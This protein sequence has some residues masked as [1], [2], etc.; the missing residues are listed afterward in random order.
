M[1]LRRFP[2][3]ALGAAALF[4]V[5]A[6]AVTAERTGDSRASIAADDPPPRDK[7]ASAPLCDPADEAEVEPNDVT[8]NL[9]AAG[10]HFCG[11]VD[12]TDVDTV[13]FDIPADA[14]FWAVGLETDPDLS[15][16]PPLD[17]T[18]D[19][20]RSRAGEFVRSDRE[21]HIAQLSSTTGKP[22]AYR[23][24]IVVPSGR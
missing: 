17:M 6:C 4:V 22:V 19:G 9:L 12:G 10:A 13:A 18:I 11:E 3:F 2:L 8:P 7:D 5:A 14:P 16:D 24:Q 15:T 1:L 23:F 21:H 20:V